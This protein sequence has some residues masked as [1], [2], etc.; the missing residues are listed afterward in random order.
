LAD[1]E[2]SITDAVYQE[3]VIKYYGLDKD[4]EAVER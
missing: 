4:E 1:F 2:K 3:E